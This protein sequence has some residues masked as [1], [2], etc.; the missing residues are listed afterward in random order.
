MSPFRR[1]TAENCNFYKAEAFTEPKR[2]KHSVTSMNISTLQ[3]KMTRK[4]GIGGKMVK[5]LWGSQSTHEP[6]RLGGLGY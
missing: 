4:A 5:K 1:S 2:F 6:E 3:I